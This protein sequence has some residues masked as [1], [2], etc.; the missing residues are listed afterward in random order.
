MGNLDLA[1]IEGKALGLW[2]R[3]G[4]KIKGVL[5][6]ALFLFIGI[7]V[8][9]VFTQALDNTEEFAWGLTKATFA[10]ICA[11]A[12]LLLLYAL[13]FSKR[14]RTIGL[15]LWDLL[16]DWTIGLIVPYNPKVL[17]RQQVAANFKEV[18]KLEA[19]VDEVAGEE[20]KALTQL[21][22]NKGELQKIELEMRNNA[23][24][25]NNPELLQRRQMSKDNCLQQIA[26]LENRKNRFVEWNKRLT[27]VYDTIKD[28]RIKLN[29]L[30]GFAKTKAQIFK[31]DVEMQIME[32]ESMASASNA[33][34]RFANVLA[35]KND[36]SF[37]G[38]RALMYMN[39]KIAED[40]A[41]LKQI[42]RRSREFT[43]SINLQEAQFDQSAINYLNE[44]NQKFL[45]SASGEA[46]PVQTI[47]SF[48]V[49]AQPK[50]KYDN[51]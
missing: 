16:M 11:G 1:Q 39:Q 34:K 42:L 10:M 28:T 37:M 7:K 45:A 40:S 48:E 44:Y 14:I 36:R 22:K 5:L 3:P 35:G 32:Y 17:A 41:D 13:F 2:N 29:Q 26:I 47:T 33:A 25:A 31:D 43:N 9:P 49:K 24:L 4:G 38:E 27:P 30:A 6:I 15:A 51:L 8:L 19:N 50:T 18:E 20:E 21:E 23:A 46:A 12:S